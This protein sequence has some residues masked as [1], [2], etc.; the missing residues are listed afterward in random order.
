MWK[1]EN[2]TKLWNEFMNYY[3]K[4][5]IDSDAKFDHEYIY[6]LEVNKV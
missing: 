1:F 4:L 3:T 2:Q 6:E 5:I